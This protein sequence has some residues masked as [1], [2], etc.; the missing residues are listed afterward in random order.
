MVC[1][2]TCWGYC[3]DCK[4]IVKLT[5]C[6]TDDLCIYCGTKIK[7]TIEHYSIGYA[8]LKGLKHI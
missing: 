4:K 7:P 5:G 6:Y 1:K 2:Y 3:K 8:I